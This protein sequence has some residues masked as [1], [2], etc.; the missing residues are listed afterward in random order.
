MLSI[1]DPSAEASVSVVLAACTLGA[2]VGARGPSVRVSHSLLGCRRPLRLR[3]R[4]TRLKQ[5][6]DPQDQRWRGLA[7]CL[8]HPHLNANRA[9]EGFPFLALGRD[10]F[11]EGLLLIGRVSD[12]Q[13]GWLGSERP[14]IRSYRY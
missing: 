5:R 1:A 8:V 11:D 2:A 10:R 13:S 7:T 12:A 3:G 6:H 14:L 4:V 9:R